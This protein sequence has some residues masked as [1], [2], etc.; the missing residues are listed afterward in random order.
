M[1]NYSDGLTNLDLPRY[2]EHVRKQDKIG[3]FIAVRPTY[4][5]HV[6]NVGE[7]GQVRGI[8]AVGD[9]DLWIN[10]GFFVFKRGIFDVIRPGEDLVREPFS[11]LIEANQLTSYRHEGFWACMDTF[12]DKQLFD[13]MDARGERP[14]EVW[15]TH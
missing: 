1:A 5:F 9:A 10:G 6:V 13:D 14:W 8:R 2:L 11:R 3:A 12:K 4:S 7:D 15:R